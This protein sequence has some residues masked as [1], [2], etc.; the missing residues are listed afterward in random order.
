MYSGLEVMKTRSVS[1]LRSRSFFAVSMPFLPSMM[2]SIKTMS[3]D[4]VC[5]AAEKLSPLPKYSGSAIRLFSRD[6]SAI[7]PPS[8]CRS[9]RLSSTI[10]IFI[11]FRPLCASI[12]HFTTDALKLQQKK[13]AAS[14]TA[15]KID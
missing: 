3:K 4:F 6:H 5:I 2:M 13:A 14:R 10:A 9:E 8:F 12:N 15:A 11:A 1:I 7:V